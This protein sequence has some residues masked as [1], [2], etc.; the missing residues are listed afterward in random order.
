M[1]VALD[2]EDADEIEPILMDAF[3]RRFALLVLAGDD[4]DLMNTHLGH[5]GVDLGEIHERIDDA[6]ELGQI[7]EVFVQLGE[8]AFDVAREFVDLAALDKIFVL[9]AMQVG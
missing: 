4:A 9:Q 6:L 2:A 5:H 7:L 1:L 8:V 3:R